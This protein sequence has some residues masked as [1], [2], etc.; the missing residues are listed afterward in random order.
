[1]TTETIH[2]TEDFIGRRL[3]A[4]LAELFHDVSRAQIQ[5]WIKEGR[6]THDGLALKASFKA[7]KPMPLLLDRPE[8]RPFEPPR[9]EEKPEN[10]EIVFEDDHLLVIHKPAGIAVHPGAGRR[11]GT[12]VNMLLGHTGGALSDMGD[13][14]RP[15]IVHRL[16]KDTS[17]LM[18]VAKTN[19][20]HAALA[21]ALQRREISRIYRALVWNIPNPVSG[22]VETRIGRDPKSRQR[23][24]VLNT[25]GKESVT[26][27]KIV[28]AFGT[29]AAL[30]ECRLETGRTHQIRVHMAHIGCPV[31]G[32]PLYAGR[33]AKRGAAFS[34]ETDGQMLHAGEIAFVHPITKVEMHF[35][36]QPPERF[37]IVSAALGI[38]F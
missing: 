15:G 12:L 25:G 5:S 8:K 24:A 14:E 2:L 1:M 17:G 6:V 35:T 28:E 31:I 18:L 27:Y 38:G 34:L 33:H 10:L 4:V 16:D 36:A 32:D 13:M 30:V 3:D 9:A 20:V 7:K 22:T 29:A 11:D 23:M 21:E 26:H 19:A 37:R